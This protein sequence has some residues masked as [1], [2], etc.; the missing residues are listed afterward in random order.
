MGSK[1]KFQRLDNAISQTVK[2][3]MEQ[4]N[5]KFQ[6]VP[7]HKHRQNKADRAIQNFKSHFIAG[8]FSVN[9]KLPQNLWDKLIPQAVITLNLLR[10]SIINPKLS[11]YQ[12]LYGNFD[13]N[14]TPMAPTGTK[15]IAYETTSTRGS[16]DPHG[17]E[18]WYIWPALDHYICWKVYIPS[19]WGI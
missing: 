13:Y 9:P 2:N 16:Y 4:N 19:T 10:R 15:V 14:A 12:Q 18:G 17:T 3:D 6:L 11:A 8:L 1:P 5:M 7:P